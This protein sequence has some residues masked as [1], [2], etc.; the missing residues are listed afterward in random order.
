MNNFL[1]VEFMKCLFDKIR[2]MNQPKHVNKNKHMKKGSNI[3][4]YEVWSESIKTEYQEKK[5]QS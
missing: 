4:L 2:R 3:Y 1:Q 5:K